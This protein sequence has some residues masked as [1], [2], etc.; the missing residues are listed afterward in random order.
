MS[1][2]VLVD[3]HLQLS[4][5]DNEPPCDLSTAP[6]KIK[7]IS[8]TQTNDFTRCP[9]RWFLKRVR[10]VPV[11]EKA[12][13][14]KNLGSEIH[15]HLE[16]YYKYGTV[17]KDYKHAKKVQGAIDNL[18]PLGPGDLNIL[19][20]ERGFSL[21]AKDCI[22]FTGKKDLELKY[23]DG[24]GIIDHKTT[25]RFNDLALKPVD[26]TQDSQSLVYAHEAYET[27]QPDAVYVAHNTIST[28]HVSRVAPLKW[29][30]IT[31]DQTSQNWG[32]QL[33]T[34]DRM[35]EI[36]SEPP[37]DWTEVEGND[38]AC[39]DYG[40]CDF[41][42]LCNARNIMVGVKGNM[43]Y[44]DKAASDL[45]A[46]LAK[47]TQNANNPVFAKEP[48][49]A[50]FDTSEDSVHS[51]QVPEIYLEEVNPVQMMPLNLA[52]AMHPMQVPAAS[53]Y[54]PVSL[55][56][57]DSPT[58]ETPQPEEEPAV[59]TA[60]KKPK[61]VKATRVIWEYKTERAIDSTEGLVEYLNEQGKEGWELV[62][63][64]DGITCTFKREES[65]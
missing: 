42:L 46:R 34:L 14:G 48:A 61:R 27:Y 40:G 24:I 64:F 51:M 49:L 62:G 59:A 29:T 38:K 16:R 58:R 55:L 57:P 47:L 2:L 22:K 32:L 12:G 18:L 56:S 3:G 23:L 52:E 43:A 6:Q 19:G 41:I 50:T 11:P 54:L 10:R 30:K 9:R 31:K 17:D 36:A 35:I 8:V 20:V 65:K 39:G 21:P 60:A 13:V 33:Q 63:F 26:L 4:T 25:S 37:S 5:D 1:H 44:D 15:N 53:D 28:T 7:S 45:M